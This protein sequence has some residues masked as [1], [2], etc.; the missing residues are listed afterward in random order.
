MKTNIQLCRQTVIIVEISKGRNWFIVSADRLVV[1]TWKTK[2]MLY[3]LYSGERERER[4][5]ERGGVEKERERG[6]ERDRERKRDREG[7]RERERG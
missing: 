1:P 7:G 4:E 6:R 5:R 3:F 2:N